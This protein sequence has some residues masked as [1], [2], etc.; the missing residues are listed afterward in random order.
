MVISNCLR[1][2]AL[3][4][5][6]IS[7]E[8][9]FEIEVIK[10]GETEVPAPEVYWMKGWGKW[11]KLHFHMIL[12]HNSRENF[13][14]NT[15]MPPDLSRRNKAMLD[16]AGKRALFKPYDSIQLLEKHG[17]SPSGIR[18]VSMTPIQDYTCGR[19]DEF[20]NAQIFINKKGWMEDIQEPVDSEIKDQNLYMP[21]RIRK[22]LDS[23]GKSHISF[24]EATDSS[25]LI[26]GITAIPVGCHHRSSTAFAINT[27]NGV[28]VFTDAIFKYRNLETGTPIG[29]AEDIHECLEAYRLLPQLGKVMP[30]YDPELR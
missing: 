17:F 19:L 28:H 2:L 12:A 4:S 1:V 29:I 9:T 21:E 5:N 8:D 22:F 18:N 30:A 25:I 11:E 14:I 26:P 10:V 3:D 23:S 15:G 6:M 13:L 20:T 27:K 7:T 16:F 24:F